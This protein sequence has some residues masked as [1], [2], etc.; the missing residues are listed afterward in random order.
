[1]DLLAAESKKAEGLRK[2]HC[3]PLYGIYQLERLL[4][5][6]GILLDQ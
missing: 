3:S 2:W 1:V 5:R 6:D 4:G